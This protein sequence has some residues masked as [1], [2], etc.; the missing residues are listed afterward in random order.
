[1]LVR[2][3]APLAAIFS[4]FPLVSSGPAPVDL[5]PR[6]PASGIDVG[7]LA[8]NLSKNTQIYVPDDSEFKTYT[9]RWSNLEAPTVNVVILPDT[10]ADV[11]QIVCYPLL[12]TGFVA[13]VRA[14]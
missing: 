5:L 10:E 13:Q 7:S 4:V 2:F 12:L 9:V 1:M 6:T 3:L 11:S 8:Q 14:S